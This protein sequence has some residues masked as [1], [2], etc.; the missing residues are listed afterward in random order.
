MKHKRNI[1]SAILILLILTSCKQ[2]FFKKVRIKASPQIKINLGTSRIN[3]DDF[4]T[5]KSVETALKGNVEELDSIKVYEYGDEANTLHYLVHYPITGTEVD[6]R[7]YVDKIKN[8]A[9]GTIEKNIDNIEINIPE[10][11]IGRSKKLTG[12]EIPD[13]ISGNDIPLSAQPIEIPIQNFQELSFTAGSFKEAKIAEGK[14]NISVSGANLP[15]TINI[16]YTGI[17]V[18]SNGINFKNF[19][20]KTNSNV[21]GELGLKGLILKPSD[22]ITIAGKIKITGTIPAGYQ[23]SG[24]LTLNI[25]SAINTF[26][27]IT[28]EKDLNLDY[29]VTQPISTDLKNLVDWIEF[30]S[31]SADI[32]LTNNLPKGNDINITIESPPIGN[33]SHTFVTTDQNNTETYNMIKKDNYKLELGGLTQLDFTANLGFPESHT[34]ANPKILKLQNIKNKHTYSLGGKITVNFDWNK[35]CIKPAQPNNTI[36]SKIPKNPMILNIFKDNEYLD[37]IDP[38]P[39]AAYIYLNSNIIKMED[40]P[41]LNTNIELLYKPKN[42]TNFSHIDIIQNQSREVS[43]VEARPDFSEVSAYKTNFSKASLFNTDIDIKNIFAK[44]AAEMQFDV[45]SSL[46]K[47]IVSKKA[48]EKNNGRA[49]FNID[50]VFDIKADATLNRAI[51]KKIISIKD[52]FSRK[53]ANKNIDDIINK[54]KELELVIKYNNQ[55]GINLKAEILNPDWKENGIHQFQ[56][57]ILLKDGE[58]EIKIKIPQNELQEIQKRIPF[59]IEVNIKFDNASNQRLKKNGALNFSAYTVTNMDIIHEF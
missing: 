17:E 2:G 3:V 34:S 39:A 53:E 5:K 29:T 31:I 43:F 41:T 26:E 19:T 38:K 25:A 18:R 7:N 57:N 49:Q 11:N 8:F 21:E 15:N 33:G 59:P 56:K 36:K 27:E 35:A 22:P 45:N 50:I 30:N 54:T 4:I 9:P 16:D 10:I 55:L 52:I 48:L 37:N 12:V 6:M 46:E 23:G 32:E 58:N 44:K 20:N 40:K 51:T 14:L 28:I 13:N 24:D 47:L 1:F 42:E